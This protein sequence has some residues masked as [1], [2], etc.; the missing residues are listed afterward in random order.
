MNDEQA[1]K[2][3]FW[4]PTTD[5]AIYELDDVGA[6]IARFALFPPTFGGPWPSYPDLLDWLYEQYLAHPPLPRSR[7]RFAEIVHLPTGRRWR[8]PLPLVRTCASCSHPPPPAPLLRLVHSRR[9]GT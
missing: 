4:R 3:A 2:A 8:H 5:W 9:A 1:K 7:E 6:R